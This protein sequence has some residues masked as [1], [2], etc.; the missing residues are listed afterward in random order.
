MW[1]EAYI[2]LAFKIIVKCSHKLRRQVPKVL[3]NQAIV[4]GFCFLRVRGDEHPLKGLVIGDIKF[5]F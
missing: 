1:K 2:C 5:V 3:P 4:N